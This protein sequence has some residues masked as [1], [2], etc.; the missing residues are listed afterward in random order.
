MAV[1]VVEMGVVKETMTSCVLAGGGATGR[2]WQRCSSPAQLPVHRQLSCPPLSSSAARSPPAQLPAHPPAA[3]PTSPVAPARLFWRSG[4][5]P[6]S[7]VPTLRR[8]PVHFQCPSLVRG[9][10]KLANELT[11][12]VPLLTHTLFEVNL[13]TSKTFNQRLSF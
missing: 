3:P 11:G 5:T 7:P 12:V 1:V 2:Y 13:F 8:R 4:P 10:E 9:K 6:S